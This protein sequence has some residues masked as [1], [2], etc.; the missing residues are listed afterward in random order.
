[1]RA[2]ASARFRW[3]PLPPL[4]LRGLGTSLVESAEHYGAR[5]ANAVGISIASLCELASRYGMGGTTRTDG[6]SSFCGPGRG[7][8]ARIE[9]LERLTGCE[10]LRHGTFWVLDD[11]LAVAGAGRNSRH[12]R[13]CPKCYLEWDDETSWDP[14]IW[15]AD[16]QLS[17]PV[18]GCDLE[19]KCRVCGT[20][21]RVAR[22]YETRRICHRCDTS[23]AGSGRVS[24][25]PD[26][27]EWAEERLAELIQMCASPGQTPITLA[28]YETFVRAMVR[29][30]RADGSMP[31]AVHAALRRVSS[32]AVRG[33]VTIR[34]LI[35]L[36]AL[37]GTTIPEMLTNPVAAASQPLIDLWSG[38]TSLEFPNGAHS[39]KIA[40]FQDCADEIVDRCSGL[41][42]PSMK[43][44]LRRMKLNRDLVC[45][46]CV[47]AYE[48]YE[49]ARIR[50]VCRGDR[51]HSERAF[52]RALEILEVSTFDPFGPCDLRRLARRVARGANVTLEAARPISR[53]ALY[54]RRAIERASHRLRGMAL[55]G[56]LGVADK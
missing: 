21:Q 12:H 42:I 46:L 11:V 2:V 7:F 13:W 56:Q 32:N 30:R 22:S 43:P 27:S 29:D 20:T 15:I 26:R 19:S 14:L 18:H 35:N 28:T 4:P 41:Y 16:V 24:R 36:C 33:R 25:R 3:T 47:D 23:L 6:V 49:A 17:C 1:M 38:Y 54:T 39:E 44:L 37:Q 8:K 45:E 52:L 51:I 10:N 31:A 5:L 55:K 53:A 48:R 40:A 9:G 50:Q 34:T